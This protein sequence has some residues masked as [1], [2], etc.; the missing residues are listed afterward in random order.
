MSQAA[1]AVSVR[2]ACSA[3]ACS[4]AV[5]YREA[6]AG[7]VKLRKRGRRTVVLVE[8]LELWLRAL[9]VLEA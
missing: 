2:D 9:P 6:R 1:I 8:D 7:R 4:R 3:S 5:L